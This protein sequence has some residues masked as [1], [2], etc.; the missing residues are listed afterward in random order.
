MNYKILFEN[1]LKR[2]DDLAFKNITLQNKLDSAKGELI[3][4]RIGLL[5]VIVGVIILYAL[6]V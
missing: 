6:T 4:Y 1:L 2:C 3:I 5:I